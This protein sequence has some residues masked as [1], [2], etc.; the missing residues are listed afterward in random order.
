ME[1]ERSL[2]RVHERTLKS[3]KVVKCLAYSYQALLFTCNPLNLVMQLVVTLSLVLFVYFHK[4][5]V[6]SGAVL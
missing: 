4:T 2:F 1:F 5:Y 3:P 6:N